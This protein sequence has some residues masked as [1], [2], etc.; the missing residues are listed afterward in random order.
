[1]S[2]SLVSCQRTL[3]ARPSGTE[4]KLKLYFDV[5]VDIEEGES[6]DAANARGRALLEGIVKDV[7]AA[8]PA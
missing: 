1:M 4:P 5:R 2:C 3:I 6:I 7:R 8:L